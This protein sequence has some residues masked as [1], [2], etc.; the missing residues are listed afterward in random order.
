M[1]SSIT[2]ATAAPLAATSAAIT[3]ISLFIIVYATDQQS[4]TLAY[5]GFAVLGWP[6]LIVS[7]FFSTGSIIAVLGVLGL[8]IDRIFTEVKGRPIFIVS[9]TTY[10]G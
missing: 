2:S 4:L 8:Y 9:E 7:I 3:G 6:S 10:D 1:M 5:V